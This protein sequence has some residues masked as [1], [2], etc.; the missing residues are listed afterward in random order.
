MIKERVGVVVSDKM[1]KMRV[2]RIERLIRHRKYL[3][4]LR[5][6]KKFYAHDETNQSK[7]GDQV[8][9]KEVRPLSKLKR[10][11]VIEVIKK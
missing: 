3:K 6:R 5:V 1:A 10:W 9:I 7:A 2:V 4:T 11:E 8:R